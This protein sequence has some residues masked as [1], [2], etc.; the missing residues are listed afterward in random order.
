MLFH[1]SH[2]NSK[3]KRFF[4][5]FMYLTS[6]LSGARVWTVLALDL[7]SLLIIGSKQVWESKWGIWNSSTIESD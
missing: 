2:Q 6:L 1:I 3:L 7:R 5:S 4:L